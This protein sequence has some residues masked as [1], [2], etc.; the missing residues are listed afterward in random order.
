MCNFCA[1]VLFQFCSN[2]KHYSL[3]MVSIRLL[4]SNCDSYSVNVLWP[5]AEPCGTLCNVMQFNIL[6]CENTVQTKLATKIKMQ[7]IKHLWQ[8]NRETWFSSVRRAWTTLSA[9]AHYLVVVMLLCGRGPKNKP[10]NYEK[11]TSHCHNRRRVQ[12]E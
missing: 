12:Q 8:S 7:H 6:Y 11:Q 5:I 1:G 9:D 3:L 4:I 2:K 10:L